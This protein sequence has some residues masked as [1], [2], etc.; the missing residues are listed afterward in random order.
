MSGEDKDISRPVLLYVESLDTA[1]SL[2]SYF[3]SRRLSVIDMEIDTLRAQELIDYLAPRIQDGIPV[4]VRF[5]GRL[6]HI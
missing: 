4:R 5:T 1:P 6:I 3:E 2:E